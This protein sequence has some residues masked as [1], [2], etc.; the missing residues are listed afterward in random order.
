VTGFNTEVPANFTAWFTKHLLGT[1][2]PLLRVHWRASVHSMTAAVRH[3]K[4]RRGDLNRDAVA[5]VTHDKR[6][7]IYA[8]GGDT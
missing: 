5:S 7:R 8:F 3:Y 2:G 4:P 1:S 6:R